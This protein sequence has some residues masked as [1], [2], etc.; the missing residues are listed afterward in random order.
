MSLYLDSAYVAKCYLEEP[1]AAA[2][3]ELVRGKT[4]LHSSAWCWAEMNCILHRHVREKRITREQA[5]E[6]QGF[7][8]QDFEDGLWVLWPVSNG[9]LRRIEKAVL[10][11]PAEVF[12]RAG[13]TVHL[14]SAREAGFT[15]I[16]SNDRHLLNA[17]P[18]FGLR[19]RTV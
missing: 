16:W 11:L 6:V 3:R 5:L 15:E 18:H 4:G 2:V 10:D 14:L 8:A 19:G 1:D 9:L 13:D 12:I 17:A 7:F